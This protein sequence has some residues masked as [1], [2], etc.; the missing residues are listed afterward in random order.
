MVL[1]SQK[2]SEIFTAAHYPMNYHIIKKSLD[3][4]SALTYGLRIICVVALEIELCGNWWDNTGQIFNLE[5]LNQPLKITISP[6]HLYKRKF[7]V[8]LKLSND[9]EKSVAAGHTNK[10]LKKNVNGYFERK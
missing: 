6:V 4:I 5:G 9:F 10:K 1:R 8:V 2:A 3:S 7:R